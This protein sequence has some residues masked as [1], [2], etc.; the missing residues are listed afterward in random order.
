MRAD[1]S[2]DNRRTSFRCLV[3]NARSPCTLR[4]GEDELPVGL[5]DESAGGF[6]VLV[7]RPPGLSV[8]QTAQL[9]TDS[10]W[11]EVRVANI[12]EVVAPE[13]ENGVRPKGPNSCF[14]VGLLRLGEQV[15]I[16]ELPMSLNCAKSS[17]LF[18]ER[19][20]DG[21][22]A[23]AVR[24]LADADDRAN[25]VGMAKP[26][27][28][29]RRFE[30]QEDDDADIW[31]RRRDCPRRRRRTTRSQKRRFCHSKA[32]TANARSSRSSPPRLLPSPTTSANRRPVPAATG[33]KD[34]NDSLPSPS[35]TCETW[36]AA[37][38]EP[39]R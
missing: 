13:G 14:R 11:F 30:P 15:L 37:W 2:L 28:A 4:V 18:F 10:G 19:V 3:V 23:H 21:R 20:S 34:R 7:D 9:R 29:H 35:R 32:A 33:P 8:G 6:S 38:R 16:D 25:P 24:H 39:R 17:F 1:D 27:L 22:N 5:L 36:F 31:C 12:R 26:V